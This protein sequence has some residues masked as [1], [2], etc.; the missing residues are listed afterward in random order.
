MLDLVI[1]VLVHRQYLLDLK[2]IQMLLSRYLMYQEIPIKLWNRFKKMIYVFNNKG[3]AEI[4]SDLN[5]N[6]TGSGS[7]K[8]DLQAL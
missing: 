1:F 3:S 8:V 5:P 6:P 2:L 4:L 7:K